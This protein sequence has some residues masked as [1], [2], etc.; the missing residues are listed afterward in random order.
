M[1]KKTLAIALFVVFLV[2]I[3]YGWMALWSPAAQSKAVIKRQLFDPDSADFRSHFR[4][5]RGGPGV[6]CGEV[7]ANNRLGGKVG[8]TR[9]VVAIE[10]SIA[11]LDPFT[12]VSL[13]DGGA[14]FDNK[15]SLMCAGR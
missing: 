15:W 8:Y 13:D 7:N 4:A 1:N 2:G 11:G 12:T 9:Y 14:G 6:W 5:V 3:G 10:E